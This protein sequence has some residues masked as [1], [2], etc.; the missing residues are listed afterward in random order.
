MPAA[1]STSLPSRPPDP[2]CIAGM[3]GSR[4][5]ASCAGRR[6]APV[7]AAPHVPGRDEWSV[8]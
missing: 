5:G 2:K 8:Q 1:L 3:R 6:Q 7:R 4:A